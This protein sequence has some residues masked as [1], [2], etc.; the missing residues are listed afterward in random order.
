MVLI[1][2]LDHAGYAFH[3]EVHAQRLI[4]GTAVVVECVE[5]L[6]EGIEFLVAPLRIPVEFNSAVDL[7]DDIVT[8]LWARAKN[9]LM[10]LV[11]RLTYSVEECR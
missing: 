9:R 10:S 4:I 3:E 2:V 11:Q 6:V 1:A 8:I 5:M 7:S